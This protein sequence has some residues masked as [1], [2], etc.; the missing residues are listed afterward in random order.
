MALPSGQ[1]TGSGW[2]IALRIANMQSL[3]VLCTGYK[4]LRCGQRHVEAF[5]DFFQAAQFEI[6]I[7]EEWASLESDV[8]NLHYDKQTG[9]LRVLT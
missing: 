8:Q 4:Q 6:S 2:W 5:H 1:I 3:R 9:M 7:G